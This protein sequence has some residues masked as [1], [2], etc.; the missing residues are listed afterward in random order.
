MLTEHQVP[1]KAGCQVVTGAKGKALGHV[2][3]DG[4]MSAQKFFGCMVWIYYFLGLN[5][6]DNTIHSATSNLTYT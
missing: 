2:F 6:E 4:M 1:D 5:P 3:G